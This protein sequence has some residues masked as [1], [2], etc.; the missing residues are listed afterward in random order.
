LVKL[1]TVL[2]NSLDV[3]EKVLCVFVDLAKAFDTVDHNIMIETLEKAGVRGITLNLF[4]SYLSDRTQCVRVVDSISGEEIVEF[5]VPQGTV[6]GP[7]LFILYINNLFS[8]ESL[9]ELICF[10]DDSAIIHI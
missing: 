9:G 7:I 3:G 6:L 8:V 5:G 10:A 1:T 4:K 2:N